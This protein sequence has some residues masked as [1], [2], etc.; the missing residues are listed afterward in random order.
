MPDEVF[1]GSEDLTEAQAFEN[2]DG[3]ILRFRKPL[4]ATHPSDHTIEQGE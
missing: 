1:G 3:T 4:K 2:D